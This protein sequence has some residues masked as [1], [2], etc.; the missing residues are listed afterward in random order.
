MGSSKE[1]FRFDEIG[2]WSKIRLE[3]LWKYAVAFTTIVSA[4]TRKG[5][6]LHPTHIDAKHAIAHNKIMIIDQATII[7]GS[8]NNTKAAE[9]KNAE[10]LLVIKGDAGAGE[11][12]PQ[13]LTGALGAF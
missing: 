12:V 7:T 9:E 13:E 10:N 6:A 2:D 1:T 8:F 3:I 5:I 11:E 4:Q